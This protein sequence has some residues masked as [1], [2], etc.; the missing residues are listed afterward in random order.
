MSAIATGS[1]AG[2]AKT[3]FDVSGLAGGAPAKSLTRP[4]D[5]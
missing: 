5:T 4:G 1:P 2:T 3:E